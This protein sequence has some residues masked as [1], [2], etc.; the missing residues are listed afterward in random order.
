M[1]WHPPPP[2]WL[3]CNC[4]RAYNYDL[5][6]AGCGGI[7]RNNHGN[8]LLSFAHKVHWSS[9]YLIKFTM[10]FTTWRF[11]RIEVGPS[12]ELKWIWPLLLKL[13]TKIICCIGKSYINSLIVYLTLHI[14]IFSHHTSIN[15]RTLVLIS[16]LTWGLTCTSANTFESIPLCIR[17]DFVKNRLEMPYFKFLSFWWDLIEPL[18]VTLYSLIYETFI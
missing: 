1:F 7:F 12:F 16:W 17:K 6:P 9:S 4:D 13:L 3:K 14:N 8:F 2:G 15:K 11:Q 10:I 18:F 5:L